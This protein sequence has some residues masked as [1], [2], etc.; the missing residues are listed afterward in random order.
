M[1]RFNREKIKDSVI[2]SLNRDY[3]SLLKRCD[4]LAEIFYFQD[5]EQYKQFLSVKENY[6]REIQTKANMIMIHLEYEFKKVGVRFD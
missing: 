1:G 6:L 2:L 4:Q 3:E 5:N